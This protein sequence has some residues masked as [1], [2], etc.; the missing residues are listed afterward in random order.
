M[1]TSSFQL[2]N[3]AEEDG[4][5]E[6]DQ[7]QQEQFHV[8][9]FA[10]NG[11]ECYPSNIDQTLKTGFHVPDLNAESSFSLPDLGEPSSEASLT[12][13]ASFTHATGAM[14]YSPDK[15]AS[16]QALLCAA[17]SFLGEDEVMKAMKRDLC[18]NT[19]FSGV[20]GG[21]AAAECLVAA[22]CKEFG[23][24]HMQIRFGLCADLSQPCRKFLARAF[25]GRCR[26]G[27]VNLW[28]SKDGKVLRQAHCHEHSMNCP[29]ETG[30]FTPQEVSVFIFG[31]PC[32]AHTKMGSG[33]R[34][35]DPRTEC[36]FV[37]REHAADMRY[38]VIVCENVLEY[39]MSDFLQGLGPDY[40]CQIITL[41]PRSLGW[42]AARERVFG[43]AVLKT[44]GVW[45]MP[46][47][48]L[49]KLLD[50]LTKLL[51]SGVEGT[52]E[53]FFQDSVHSPLR[54][55]ESMQ[56]TVTAYEERFG[57]AANRSLAWDL[58]QNPRKR[59]R[60]NRVDGSLQTLMRRSRLYSPRLSVV[61]N[62]TDALNVMG[63]PACPATAETTG[64][65]R[66]LL[67][68]QGNSFTESGLAIGF[69]DKHVGRHAHFSKHTCEFTNTCKR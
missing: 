61:L 69:R 53:G 26:F 2:C 68:L 40:D 4:S 66:W 10:D 14:S 8:P 54:L 63:F 13:S 11:L 59:P 28:K 17:M 65:R 37:A 51:D 30:A 33:L 31:G 43:V 38:N 45:R 5:A 9:D 22:V 67:A 46:L 7:Q 35:A 50:H 52:C 29:L 47:S 19:V 32:V 23:A 3:L 20:G 55:T 25:P 57:V 44:W 39:P 62:G 34:F 1:S 16:G 27:N 58:T 6:H 48:D 56:A 36:H 64:V 15:M 49:I 42:P 24:S 41:D 12:D 21:E 60:T 18:I